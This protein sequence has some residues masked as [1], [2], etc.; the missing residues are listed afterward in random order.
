MW[1]KVNELFLSGLNKTQIGQCV[2]LHRQTI[3]KYL[4]M[5]EENKTQVAVNNEG[6][7]NEATKNVKEPLNSGQTR[8]DEK[9]Q[10]KQENK[11]KKQEQATK[12]RGRRM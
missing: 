12:K 3:S 5:T 8:P 4:S 9:Q 7:T 10:A 1:N 6:K 2:G 11:E